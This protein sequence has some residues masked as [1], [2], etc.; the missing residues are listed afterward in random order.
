MFVTEDITCNICDQRAIEYAIRE[1]N[2]KIKVIRRTFKYLIE[3]AQ[4]RPNKE[5]FVLVFNQYFNY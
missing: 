4:L 3:N 2:L 5:L 1:K